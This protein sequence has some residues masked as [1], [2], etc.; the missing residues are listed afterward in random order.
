MLIVFYFF[1][2]GFTP[3]QVASLF[4]FYEVFGI[5]TNLIGGYIGARVGLKFAL[6]AGL[7]TQIMA[8]GMLD[9]VDLPALGGWAVPYVMV[10]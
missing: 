8:L 3:F 1:T 7:S 6:F 9:I 4:I 2:L 5:V 10:A